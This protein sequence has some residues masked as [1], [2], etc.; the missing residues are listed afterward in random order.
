M[1]SAVLLVSVFLLLIHLGGCERVEQ[2]KD[3]LSKAKELK[4]D[5]QKRSDDIQKDLGD[6]TEDYKDR[7]RKKAG[8]ASAA[9]ERI[10]GDSD[11]QDDRE[12]KQ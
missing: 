8:L 5:F 7:I 11:R 6:K 4:S 3:A 1:K 2:A 10:K 9:E 12:D